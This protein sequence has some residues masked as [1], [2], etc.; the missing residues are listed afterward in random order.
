M[1]SRSASRL[2]INTLE[3][4]T[5]KI[6]LIDEDIDDSDRVIFSDIIIKSFRE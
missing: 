6:K 1:V 5:S 2:W 4:K 3:T